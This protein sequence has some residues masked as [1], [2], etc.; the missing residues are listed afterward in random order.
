M[1]GIVNK[2][3]LNSA[4]GIFT[5]CHEAHLLS[6]LHTLCEEH[7]TQSASWVGVDAVDHA[8]AL[9]WS[10][11]ATRIRPAKLGGLLSLGSSSIARSWRASNDEASSCN[12]LRI[13]S[14]V[15][16]KGPMARASLTRTRSE[17]LRTIRRPVEDDNSSTSSI[18]SLMRTDRTGST[19][20]GGRRIK[21]NK[22]QP[23]ELWRRRP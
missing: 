13:P 8:K 18:S 1:Q 17:A 2:V 5:V 10:S 3:A 11:R 19:G 22:T 9:G 16:S 20:F 7:I 15:S 4:E 23:V 12:A 6:G 14:R 21:R